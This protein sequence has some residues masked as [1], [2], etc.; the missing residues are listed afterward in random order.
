MEKIVIATDFTECSTNALNFAKEIAK[1][2]YAEL[3]ITSIV[4]LQII[5]PV[6][7]NF[8]V[9]PMFTER[10][11]ETG[12]QLDQI[13]E[14]LHR[15]H[16]PDGRELS[17]SLETQLG[18]PANEIIKEARK[19]RADLIV[20]GTKGDDF[21][22]R[23]LGNTSLDLSHFSEIPLLI[24]P[25]QAAYHGFDKILYT[26]DL[27]EGDEEVLKR[28]IAFAKIY[29]AEILVLHVNEKNLKKEEDVF[30]AFKN[31][32]LQD[33]EYGKVKFESLTLKDTSAILDTVIDMD[34]YDMMV[35]R[36]LK[37]NT[38][39]ELFH[40]SLTREKVRNSEI[41]LLIFH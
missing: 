22:S 31:E 26:T 23:L 11:E 28:V 16:Y 3:H 7:P 33:L 5:D 19:L 41:P 8:Y 30:Q 2:A 14:K 27:V 9:E 29:N 12:R 37:R 32:I 18:D 13:R 34:K 6:V 40:K 1:K 4:N 20:A 24:V 36:K 10:E 35:L 38:L 39:S 17:V 21:P 15:E 25:S